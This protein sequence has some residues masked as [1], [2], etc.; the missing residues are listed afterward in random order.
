MQLL[1]GL[2]GVPREG[3]IHVAAENGVGAVAEFG[4]RVEQPQ[5]AL[6]AATPVP[7]LRLSVK[8]LAVLVVGA[9]GAGA[10]VDLVVVVLARPLEH[11]PELECVAAL[12]PGEAVGRGHRSDPK[13]AT[14]TDRR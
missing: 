1:A 11:A 6:A 9:G 10:D 14:D 4:V 7:E 12:H 3:F 2:P 5:A 13:S 8:E